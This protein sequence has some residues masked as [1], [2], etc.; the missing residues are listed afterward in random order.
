MRPKSI[1]FSVE[2]MW[3]LLSLEEHFDNV[4]EGEIS[5]TQT[6]HLI[7]VEAEAEAVLLFFD[8]EQ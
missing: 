2:I 3:T 1:N 8:H 5:P 6:L 7:E 4:Q